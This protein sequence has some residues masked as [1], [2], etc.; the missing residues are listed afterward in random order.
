[1]RTSFVGTNSLVKY[2]MRD[3]VAVTARQ[4][5]GRRRNE[6][7]R[8]A[9]LDSAVILLR[10]NDAAAVSVDAIAQEA[11]VSKQTIYRW[12][13][14]KG[15]VLLEALLDR[16]EVLAPTPDTGDLEADLRMFLT[17]TFESVA[18]SRPVLLGVLREAL[19]DSD[20]MTLLAE[21]AAHRRAALMQIVV[22]ASERGENI[23]TTTAA[24]VVDQA[25]GLLW[26]RLIFG[27]AALDKQAA[28]KLAGAAVGQLR[29]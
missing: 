1:M 11:G 24:L 23:E 7:A 17:N 15:A 26:Y 22:Q 18:D 12:W 25:F 16:A 29:A 10:S 14:S 27:N 21:F 20:A 9:I 3:T 4:H 8:Q 2:E 19:A 28:T 5:T 6:A 13:P